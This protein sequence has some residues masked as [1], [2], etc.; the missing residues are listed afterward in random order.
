MTAIYTPRS[1][2]SE[3]VALPTLI[4]DFQPPELGGRKRQL[5]GPPHRRA[6]LR[7][8]ELT[9]TRTPSS[10]ACAL[11]M[12]LTPGLLPLSWLGWPLPVL[13]DLRPLPHCILFWILSG[14]RMPL[15]T[16][17][18]VTRLSLLTP[19]GSPRSIWT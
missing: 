14:P 3:G 6:L 10:A 5:F 15:N 7:V 18:L 11:L 8:S 19:L 13:R 1:Q 16:E 12:S 9:R 2:A 4:L 17:A